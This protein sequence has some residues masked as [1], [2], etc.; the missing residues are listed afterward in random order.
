[1]SNHYDIIITG[2]VSGGSTIANK[3]AA[4]GF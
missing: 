2:T 1:M 4:S 3:L